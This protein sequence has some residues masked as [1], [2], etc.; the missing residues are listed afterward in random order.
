MILL[1]VS[2]S[3]IP[4]E[5]RKA[6]FFVA[7]YI[8]AIGEAGQ[9]AIIQTFAVNQFEESLS[10]L[11]ETRIAKGS[12]FNWCYFAAIIGHVSALSIVI[13]VQVFLIYPSTS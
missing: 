12:F 10:S 4:L 8:L 7:L 3:V 5:S 1:T 9:R 13:Y 6:V 11:Q 2:V